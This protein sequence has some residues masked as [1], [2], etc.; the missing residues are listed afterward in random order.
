MYTQSVK[1]WTWKT[2]VNHPSKKLVEDPC[3]SFIAFFSFISLGKTKKYSI[4]MIFWV[5]MIFEQV[6]FNNCL[7]QG[8]PLVLGDIIFSFVR[9]KVLRRQV[10]LHLRRTRDWSPRFG[11]PHRLASRRTSLGQPRRS[12]PRG[13]FLQ[14]AWIWS[15]SG[16]LRSKAVLPNVLLLSGDKLVQLAPRHFSDRLF[17]N[18]PSKPNSTWERLAQ[19]YTIG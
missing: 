15:S 11:S 4:K 13:R 14:Q 16:E 17:S 8:G 7:L 6:Y 12:Q 1:Q 10:Q 5:E 2:L 9:S 19:L 3:I 18:S